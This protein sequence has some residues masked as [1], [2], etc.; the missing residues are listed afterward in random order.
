M[1]YKVIKRKK[2]GEKILV[3]NDV[4]MG[5]AIAFCSSNT[6]GHVLGIPIRGTTYFKEI[7]FFNKKQ[8]G[9]VFKVLLAK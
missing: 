7:K 1:K 9:Y 4:F 8:K 3:K 6:N 5:D 2:N